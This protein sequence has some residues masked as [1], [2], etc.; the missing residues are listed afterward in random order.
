MED[1]RALA[2][3]IEQLLLSHHYVMDL[4]TDGI[5]GRGMAEVFPYDL[6]LMDWMLPKLDG[7]QLCQQLRNEGNST[8]IILLTARD[9]STDRVAGL[10]AG[11]DDYLVKPFEFEELLARIRALLRRSEGI[12][13]PVLQWGDLQLDPCSSRVTCGDV[14]IALTPK[15]YA[16]LEL[17]LR[18]P[19]RIFSLDSLLDKV[20]P[21]E[22]TPTVAS[23]RTH[24]KGLRQKLRQVGLSDVISTVYG[25]G[26]RLRTAAPPK[27]TTPRTKAT[28]ASTSRT[29]A[30]RPNS[31]AN[32][33]AIEQV[34]TR[35]IGIEQTDTNPIDKS[36]RPQQLDLASLWQGVSDSYLQRIT[37]VSDVFRRLQ[38]GQPDLTVRQQLLSEA[39]ALAGSLGSFGFKDVAIQWREIESTLRTHDDLSAELLRQLEERIALISQ[40]LR[41]ASR[42]PRSPTSSHLSI[43]VITEPHS[44]EPVVSASVL[45]E[46]PSGQPFE[47]LVVDSIDRPSQNKDSVPSWIQT[48]EEVA[49]RYQVK[50]SIANSIGQARDLIF[51][52]ED[53]NGDA[54][55]SASQPHI[56]LFNFDGPPELPASDSDEFKLLAELRA[57]QSSL[58]VIV[59]AAEASFENRVRV[60]RLGVSRLLQAPTSPAEILETAVRILQKRTPPTA[61]LLVVDDDS[62]MLTLLQKLLQPWGFK[63][64]ILCDPSQFW[65]T[66]E[67]VEPDLLLLDIKMPQL[68][69][70][71]LCQVV[72]SDPRWHELP[73]LFMSAHTDEKT[74]QE[75]FSV[76]ADDYIRKPIVAPELVAR[77]LGWLARSRDRRL[78]TEID[79]LTGLYN[80]RK[81]TQS[82]NRLLRLARRQRQP[83]CFALIDLD[84]FKQINDQYGH[85]V[86]DYVL[87]RFGICLRSTFRSEDV[88]ARWGGE[89]F[90]IGLYGVDALEG[91]ERLR[92][93]VQVWQ[94][95]TLDIC[96]DLFLESSTGT[97]QTSHIIA[98]FSAGI[99]VF[100]QAADSLQTLYIA[101]DRALHDAKKM[102]RNRV[103]LAV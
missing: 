46:L 92:Q 44:T 52:S 99:A 17:F 54:N 42:Q 59:L 28:Y 57:A 25:L 9:A 78:R 91:T 58:P 19:E 81:S 12:V 72:R 66:L 70:F 79:S 36:N 60:A 7:M 43:P 73:I 51:L 71:D 47:L 35:P 100:P 40:S 80:R 20:W 32:Q 37:K 98:T 50:V 22:D 84:H 76:G 89:E 30:A 69:G 11:A 82:L 101:A 48:L 31:G 97:A 23:V 27:A 63:I 15:E 96:K 68:S 26:Y 62:S 16:L 13:S 5:E 61:T 55:R 1:D 18:N 4:A 56:A 102:G 8:P 65:Q 103:K 86:G 74:I 14:P 53:V 77:V 87:R 64:E 33:A 10:D 24:I 95:E 34:N 45:T 90:V 67:K 75:V 2:G 94:N 21:F 85:L 39:H 83:L 88:V 29:A 93:L 38:P 49:V 6:I 3:A 41:Q